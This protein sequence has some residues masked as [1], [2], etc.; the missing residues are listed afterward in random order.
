VIVAFYISLDLVQQ[1]AHDLQ[2][3]ASIDY[4]MQT[5]LL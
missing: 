5:K 1:V 2:L 4:A 3:T